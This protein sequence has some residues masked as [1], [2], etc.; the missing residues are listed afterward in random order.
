MRKWM[1]QGEFARD[2]LVRFGTM[3]PFASVSE[4]Y[5]LLSSDVFSVG[6]SDLFEA[7]GELENYM[8]N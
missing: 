1:S 3:G 5:P 6:V 8:D 2:Q 7:H 4:L